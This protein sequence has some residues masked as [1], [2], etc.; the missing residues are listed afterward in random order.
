MFWRLLFKKKAK[1]KQILSYQTFKT[2]ERMMVCCMQLTFAVYI[3]YGSDSINDQLI[4][5]VL[6]L[7]G[8]TFYWKNE[9]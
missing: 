3:L 5:S 8:K 1:L 9:N 4:Q 7:N 6:N 2:V